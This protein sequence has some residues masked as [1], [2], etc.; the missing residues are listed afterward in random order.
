VSL[1]RHQALSLECQA[2]HDANHPPSPEDFL[3][4]FLKSQFTALPYPTS[5]FAGQT[6][7]ITGA[8]TGLGLE[9]AR[10]FARLGAS[11]VILGCRSLERGLAAKASIEESLS[12][13]NDNNKDTNNNV[14]E[15][16][17]VDL[18]SY[19][20]VKEF[21]RK[22]EGLERVDAVVENAGLATPH[23][24]EI[25]SM[26]STIT[27]NVISTFLMSL[28]LLPKLRADA[29]TYN[30]VPH[31]TIVASDAHMQVYLFPKTAY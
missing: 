10:H 25:E 21:C 29:V 13:N 12:N 22:V 6:I 19:E 9:A 11:K 20:S 24:E 2:E 3:T 28:L 4:S 31:L 26:E 23:Y 5:S 7:I 18:T 30:I 8:N 15:V 27:V 17:Q 14:V 1:H 16:W